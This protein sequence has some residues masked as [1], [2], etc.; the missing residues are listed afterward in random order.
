MCS[1]LLVRIE[2]RQGVA[3]WVRE[4]GADSVNDARVRA[5]ISGVEQ[6]SK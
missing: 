2:G 4:G 1:I 6:T 3:E 5:R